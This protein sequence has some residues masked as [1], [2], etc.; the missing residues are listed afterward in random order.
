MNKILTLSALLTPVI[1]E[2]HITV[3]SQSS[4]ESG[5]KIVK[6]LIKRGFTPKAAA[7]IAG[8]MWQESRFNPKISHKN[9]QHVGVVQWG[10][11][12]KQNLMKRSGWSRLETQLDFVKHEF[13]TNDQFKKLLKDIEKM[14]LKKATE[15]VARTYEGSRDP[16]HPN[17]NSA[18]QKLFEAYK[19][20][21]QTVDIIE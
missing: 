20:E 19:K 14:S 3:M 4:I 7:A 1:Y 16:H 10:G 12:R 17:R 2:A 9:S 15:A 8:N 5:L 13:D 11:K 18:A 6:G 21:K